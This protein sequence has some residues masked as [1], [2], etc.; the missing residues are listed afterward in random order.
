MRSKVLV[1]LLVGVALAEDNQREPSQID[2]LNPFQDPWD[3]KSE[4]F[5]VIGSTKGHLTTYK[6]ECPSDIP[7]SAPPVLASATEGV[8]EQI[9]SKGSEIKSDA[10][11][12]IKSGLENLIP[13]ATQTP[14]I[15]RRDEAKDCTRFQYFITQGPN[16]YEYHYSDPSEK[17]WS[18]EAK[19]KWAG[20][21]KPNQAEDITC[22]AS[23]SGKDTILGS[24]TVEPGK[25]TAIY[26]PDDEADVFII[27][28]VW[29][30]GLQD[31]G[32]D[33]RLVKKGFE[34]HAVTAASIFALALFL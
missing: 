13:R 26:K 14:T 4:N 23:S 31:S 10:K 25:V 29:V 34:I 21:E 19:C 11:S 2:L 7:T 5:T 9:S 20:P 27:Q 8:R 6:V 30:A 32:S 24:K 1:A 33:P 16:T 18:V 28:R 15:T 22:E 3:I 12:N 17:A